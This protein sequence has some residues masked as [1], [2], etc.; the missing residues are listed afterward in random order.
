MRKIWKLLK[1]HWAVD[2]NWKLYGCVALFLGV[3]IAINY[4]INLENGIIDKHTGEPI[5]VFYYFLL[6][7]FSY[8]FTSFIV[9]SFNKKLEYFKSARYWVITF[10]ILAF[11]SIDLGFPF[12]HRLAVYFSGNA[13]NLYKWLFGITNNT[14]SFVVSTLPLFIFARYFERDKENFGINSKNIDFGPY[15]QILMIV[16]PLVLIASF[17]QSFRNYYPMYRRYDISNINPTNIPSWL[18]A[19]GFETVYGSDFFNV[20]F[21]FR[22]AMVIG[23]SQVIGK[24][25]VL[26]MVASYCVLHFGK[27]LGECVSSIFGGYVLGVIALYTRNIWGG[28]IVHVGLAWMMETLA[29]IQKTFS[30]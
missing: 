6:Q 10:A 25:A 5:R 26:P 17:E 2:F 24:E 9:F 19:V 1:Q 21:M 13:T 4:K 16:F 14:V 30:S 28:V 11:L 23:V 22:G 20:E 27:P 18:F 7:A 12:T 8:L 15:W 29:F 3:F